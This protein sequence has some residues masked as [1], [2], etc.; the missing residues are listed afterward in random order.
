MRAFLAKLAA[1]GLFFGVT[2][3]AAYS[4]CYDTG[5]NTQ[6]YCLTEQLGNA[7]WVNAGLHEYIDAPNHCSVGLDYFG[8]VKRLAVTVT[9]P[10]SAPRDYAYVFAYDALGRRVGE[11][12]E[13]FRAVSGGRAQADLALDYPMG[14]AGAVAIMEDELDTHVPLTADYAFGT[15]IGAAFIHYDL[16]SSAKIVAPNVVDLDQP[17]EVRVV[18]NPAAW[19][20]VSLRWV[21]SLGPIS[22]T[23]TLLQRSYSTAGQRTFAVVLRSPSR[24]DSLLLIK[25]VT[26]A[27]PNPPCGNGSPC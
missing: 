22:P 13:L 24:S 26:V 8:Q 1:G 7:D 21:S 6:T 9:A 25:A 14:F 23:P 5:S 16:T 15:A 19:P 27:D 2:G 20:N 17:F 12:E 11:T 10:S 18:V 3:M 4:E